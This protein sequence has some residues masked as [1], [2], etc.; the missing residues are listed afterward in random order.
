MAGLLA[1]YAPPLFL[2]TAALQP[3]I[4]LF[5]PP[6]AS[7]AAA[8]GRFPAFT[9]FYP[10]ICSRPLRPQLSP[11]CIALP[12]VPAFLLPREFATN[13][14]AS[15][16]SSASI[17]FFRPPPASIATPRAAPP[18]FS[19]LS[20][21]LQ[22]PAPPPAFPISITF[23]TSTRKQRSS[24]RSR[25]LPAPRICN[26]PFRLP[27]VYS[28]CIAFFHPSPESSAAPRAVPPLFSL[29]SRNLQ[30]SASPPFFSTSISLPP[31]S[32]F[33]GLHP[34]A[35]QPPA[36]PPLF[37]P[38]AYH[39]RPRPLPGLSRQRSQ[40]LCR[41]PIF[42]THVCLRTDFLIACL[43]TVLFPFSRTFG[44]RRPVFNEFFPKILRGGATQPHLRNKHMILITQAPPPPSPACTFPSAFRHPDRLLPQHPR[45][46]NRPLNSPP[47][48]TRKTPPRNHPFNP[49][50]SAPSHRK[51][52]VSE[53]P[54]CRHRKIHGLKAYLLPPTATGK[55]RNIPPIIS[56]SP[57]KPRT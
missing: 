24:V 7:I 51:T 3:G 34:S 1:L 37:F 47:P 15:L 46:H 39:I 2:P 41:K 36:P 12:P 49:H 18:L 16:V 54:K 19:L 52:P 13:L 30:S 43:A 8:Q 26:H 35:L 27:L 40:R 48:D 29:L 53:T 28:A 55:N 50:I 17:A 33:Y 11:S 38:R 57:K 20:K 5:R 25:V 45:L 14:S 9:T 21:N 56:P 10:G 22:P 32:A 23:P 44:I 42:R 4:S 31:F 6:P